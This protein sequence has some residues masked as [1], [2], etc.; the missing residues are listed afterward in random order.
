MGA[1]VIRVGPADH[2]RRMR[3]ADFEHAEVQEGYL[4]E[5][6]RGI[7]VVSDVPKPRH[8]YPLLAIRNPLV[9]YQAANPGVIHAILA[10]SECKILAPGYESE[11]HPDLSVYKTPPPDP[12]DPWP[13]WIPEIVVEILSPSSGTRDRVL[14]AEEYLAVGVR[15]YW[16]VDGPGQ[17]IQV[18]RRWGGRWREKTLRPGDTYQTRFLPGFTLDVAAV[19]AAGESAA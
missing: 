7:L 2:G 5:L 6:E 13:N 15:E 9:L 4:Y 14:K 8:M 12:D 11:R 1:A 16:I 18:R 19:L 17:A 10:G 3:L